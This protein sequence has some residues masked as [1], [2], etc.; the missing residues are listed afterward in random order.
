MT[1]KPPA[2]CGGFVHS[3]PRDSNKDATRRTQRPAG[4]RLD[5]ATRSRTATAEDAKGTIGGRRNDRRW[6]N[7]E[8]RLRQTQNGTRFRC[9]SRREERKN[10]KA[11]TAKRLEE[12]GNYSRRSRS[13]SGVEGGSV[14]MGR[15]Q[16]RRADTDETGSLCRPRCKLVL[17]QV[18]D[19]AVMTTGQSREAVRHESAVAKSRHPN[20]RQPAISKKIDNQFAP[21]Q[22]PKT[23]SSQ[24]GAR[25]VSRSAKLYR[26]SRI[27]D[28]GVRRNDA[29]GG[30]HP[31]PDREPM[32]WPTANETRTRRQTGI[33]LR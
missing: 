16:G 27:G 18:D 13:A 28:A 6:E 26:Q 23:L 30:H 5:L 19:G 21:G 22:V 12:I 25:A 10:A 3:H 9:R 15:R 33:P 31:K 29:G 11:A 2:R 20:D 4:K 1:G 8:R 7:P 32:R 17:H 24:T 14:M